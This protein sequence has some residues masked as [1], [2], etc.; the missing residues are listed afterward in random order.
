M[1]DERMKAK[2]EYERL[3]DEGERRKYTV[4]WNR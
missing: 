1:K 4:H 3:K 2:G